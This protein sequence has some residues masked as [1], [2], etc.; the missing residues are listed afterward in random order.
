MRYQEGTCPHCRGL[1]K[2]EHGY[3]WSYIC[4]QCGRA[5]IIVDKIYWLAGFSAGGE[6]YKIDKGELEEVREFDPLWEQLWDR[7]RNPK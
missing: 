6:I 5:W 4:T 7:V 1:L 2:E 3:G